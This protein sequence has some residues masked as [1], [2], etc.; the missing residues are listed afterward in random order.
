MRLP[1]DIADAMHR[2]AET[3]QPNE[4]CGLLAGSGRDV[5]FFYPLANVDAR[6]DRYTLD[7]AGHVK[8]LHHADERGWEL[9]GVFHS[10]PVSPAVP[11]PIDLAQALEPDW[12]YVIHGSDGLRAWRLGTRRPEEVPI[13][14]IDGR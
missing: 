13:E 8:A 10:H 6:P 14:L 3:A 12:L 11:S 2:H 9:I 5:C 1:V 7:P 4:A